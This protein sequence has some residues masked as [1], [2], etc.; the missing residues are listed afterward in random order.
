MTE[1]I[2]NMISYV[3]T[4]CYQRTHYPTSY[5]TRPFHL[6]TLPRP[7]FHPSS[8]SSKLPTKLLPLPDLHS[9]KLYLRRHRHQR[10]HQYPHR[11]RQPNGPNLELLLL[12]GA[13]RVGGGGRVGLFLVEAVEAVHAIGGRIIRSR[14]T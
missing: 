12:F 10:R 3:N 2:D 5:H 13:F 8:E 7:P 4:I 9:T 11:I 14:E 1:Q 6:L